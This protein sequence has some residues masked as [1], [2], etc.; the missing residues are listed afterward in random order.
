MISKNFVRRRLRAASVVEAITQRGGK[1]IAVGAD[2]S[3]TADAKE[4]IEAA[5]KNFGRLDILVNN[6]GAAES[7]PLGSITE[8]SFDK[9]F[10]CG[11][12]DF[13]GFIPSLYVNAVGH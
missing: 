8:A 7:T 1:A 10:R 3:A 2:V 4:I 11:K 13:V 9:I 12:G 6:S 5:I